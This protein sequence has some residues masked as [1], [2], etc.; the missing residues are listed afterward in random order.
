MR[1][2]RSILAASGMLLAAA[3]SGQAGA[4]QAGAEHGARANLDEIRKVSALRKAEVL[5]QANEKIAGVTDLILAPDGK[6]R[7]A[8]LGVGGVVGIGAK[9]TAIP[10]EKLDVRHV[11]DKWAVNL[12][13]TRQALEQAPMFESDNYRELTNPQWVSR[14]HDFFANQGGATARDSDRPSTSRENFTTMYLASKVLGAKLQNAGS[15]NL[16]SVEDL[17]LDRNSRAAFAII[18]HGGVLGIGENYIPVPWSK[19]KLTDR[20]DSG[21]LVATIDSTKDQIEK[22]PLVKGDTYATMLAPGFTDQVY[23]Y[24]GVEKP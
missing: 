24:F 2:R 7:Y 12:P 16:G 6:V 1:H 4:Q 13:M 19:L 17:L 10:W 9:Y 11:N 22:A 18:G 21:G 14:V 3:L 8:I 20:Q 5:N 15:E 23:K